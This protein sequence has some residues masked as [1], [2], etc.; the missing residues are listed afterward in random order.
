MG[1]GSRDPVVLARQASLHHRLP[2]V[3]PPG[4]ERNAPPVTLS[5]IHG[6]ERHSCLPCW[7]SVNA[8]HRRRNV[9]SLRRASL[10]PRQRRE[11]VSPGRAEPWRVLPWEPAHTDRLT[12]RARPEWAREGVDCGQ[13][14][15]ARCRSFATS[16]ALLQSAA[17][18]DTARWRPNPG[19]ARS[20]R[21]PG[22]T[23]AGRWPTH[24][25]PARLTNRHSHPALFSNPEVCLPTTHT[26]TRTHPHAHIHTLTHPPA[27]RFPPRIRPRFATSPALPL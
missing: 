11:G 2:S 10:L 5:K 23:P 8:S 1:A 3:L 6:S 27:A 15:H 22:L 24:A 16:P 4:A 18:G 13:V 19:I 7:S 25:T 21:R 9:P 17:L 26:S 14:G 20:S 12:Q